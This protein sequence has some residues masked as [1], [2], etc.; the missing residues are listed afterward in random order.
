MFFVPGVLL[1]IGLLIVASDAVAQSNPRYVRFTPATVKGALYAPDN[2]P[3]P[4]VAILAIHRTANYM[5]YLGCTELS[6]RGFLVLCMNPRSDNNEAKVHWEDNAL[7]V[8]SGVSYLRAQPGITKV[9]LWGFSGG[10]ATTSF[11]QA[12]AENGPSYCQGPNKLIAC[13]DRLANLPRAD[14]LILVD[15]N[16]GNAASALRRVNAAVT[17]DASIIGEN[18]RAAIDPT[19]DPFSSVNGYN[20]KGASSFDAAFQRRYFHA[21]S[22]RMNRLI[23]IALARLRAMQSG[24]AQYADDDVFLVVKGDG[25]ELMMLDPAIHDRTRQPQKLLKNDGGVVR[26]VV[27][28]VRRPQPQLAGLNASFTDGTLF[29][30]VHSFL[31]A[32]AIRSTHA[33]D[34]IDWCSS[35]NSVPCAL[36]AISAPLLVT[37]MGAN[38]YLRFNETHYE[39]AKS[40]DKDFVIVEG[41]NHGQT[42]CVPCESRPGQYSNTVRNFFDYTAAWIR[43][44]Y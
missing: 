15:T 18:R 13:D 21:Q 24:S 20:P 28:S 3:A 44:R 38:S 25:A 11:Y 36:Q 7:D 22:A 37:A 40:T 19:L 6:Q 29:L 4:R 39:L 31:S 41:A 2:G 17:N 33:M 42:P 8:K 12:V 5:G 30:T 32:N 27:H 35:N 10:G 1:C 16:P 23:E 26:Q 14:G 43:A 9:L 34:E